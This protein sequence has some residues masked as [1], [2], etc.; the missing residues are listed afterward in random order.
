MQGSLRQRNGKPPASVNNTLNHPVPI[1]NPNLS[2]TQA[3]GKASAKVW[4]LLNKSSRSL[5]WYENCYAEFQSFGELSGPWAGPNPEHVQSLDYT[6]AVS[7]LV[8]RLI[9]HSTKTQDLP[10]LIIINRFIS[11][12]SV[13]GLKQRTRKRARGWIKGRWLK[14]CR[15]MSLLKP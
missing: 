2:R 1:N 7:S 14:P 4:R 13:T 9:N 12:S 6:E 8:S 5:W 10:S 3:L 15:W 11:K